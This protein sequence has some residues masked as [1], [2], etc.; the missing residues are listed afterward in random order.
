[1]RVRMKSKRRSG[2][3]LVELALVIPLFLTLV[4]GMMEM[5]RLAPPERGA[6]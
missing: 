4:F 1:M 6:G 5:A 3:A 2:A